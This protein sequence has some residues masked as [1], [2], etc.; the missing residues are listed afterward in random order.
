MRFAVVT[1]VPLAFAVAEEKKARKLRRGGNKTQQLFDVAAP[2]PPAAEVVK[3]VEEVNKAKEDEAL[4]DRLLGETTELSFN[5]W[6]GN[7]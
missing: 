6:Y 7:N 4:W 2:A 3:A 5:P 1:I